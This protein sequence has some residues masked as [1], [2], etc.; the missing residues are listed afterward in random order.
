[1]FNAVAANKPV[2]WS[3]PAILDANRKIQ[4]LVDAGGFVKGFNSISTDSDPE[5][6]L[7]RISSVHP[8]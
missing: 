6:T 1:M 5:L 7:S 2:A 8:G 4:Q 3:D